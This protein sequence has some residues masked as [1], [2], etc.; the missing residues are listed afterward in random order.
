MKDQI[1][2]LAQELPVATPTTTQQA[3]AAMW[4]QIEF[5]KQVAKS[6]VRFGLLAS[7]PTEIPVTEL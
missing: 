7:D 1:T 3:N 6:L 2:A 5:D 4:A